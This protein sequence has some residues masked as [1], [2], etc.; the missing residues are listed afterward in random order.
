M[1]PLPADFSSCVVSLSAGKDSVVTLLRVLELG[2]PRSRLLCHYQVVPEEWPQC[3]AY[4]QDLCRR[5]GVRLVAEQ[6]V[7]RPVPNPRARDPGTG[8]R[9]AFIRPVYSWADVVQDDPRYVGGVL[10]LAR[11]RNGQPPTNR[12]RFCTS[13]FKERLL[14]VRIGELR[15]GEAPWKF[16]LGSTPVVALGLRAAESPRRGRRP[17]LET[18]RRVTLVSG[19]TATNAYPVLEWSRR[20]VFRCLDHHDV[21][22]HPCYDWLGLRRRERLGPGEGGPRC[23]C[24]CCIY[25]PPDQIVRAMQQPAGRDTLRRVVA[26]ERETQKTWS[27]R[28]AVTETLQKAG[29]LPSDW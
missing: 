4:N 5:L 13:Y 7:Y 11:R 12:I 28:Y 27:Q 1:D 22:P 17:P 9:Q 24:L 2:W 21:E 19:F 18:R 6:L 15:R 29:R 26:F 3:L 23:S 8:V 25:A 10:D 20:D 16:P 14:D